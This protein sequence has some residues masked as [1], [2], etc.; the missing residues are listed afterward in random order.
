MARLPRCFAAAVV[1]LGVSWS[2][3][4]TTEGKELQ[5]R[6]PPKPPK[7]AVGPPKK[8][9]PRREGPSVSVENQQ[10]LRSLQQLAPKSTEAKQAAERVLKSPESLERVKE[11]HSV[12]TSFGKLQ[13]WQEALSLLD[14][15]RVGRWPTGDLVLTNSALAVCGQVG[16]WQAV[17]ALLREAKEVEVSPDIISYNLAMEAACNAQQWQAVLQLREELGEKR[18]KDFP[19][20]NTT[21]HACAQGRLWEGGLDLLAEMQRVKLKPTWAM[22]N[23]GILLA[24][25]GP[26]WEAALGFLEDMWSNVVMPDAFTY[27][28]VIA[29]CERS[30]RW[31]EAVELV[32]AM[33]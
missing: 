28:S 17:L 15:K 2:F 8:R 3:A 27:G 26:C 32:L 18:K 30:G 13:L 12:M 1:A 33:R 24:G 23:L 31:Q 19:S 25:D 6:R 11:V 21:L 16:E 22:Y 5:T 10:L 7:P 29:V 14:L 9:R 4:V 20:F